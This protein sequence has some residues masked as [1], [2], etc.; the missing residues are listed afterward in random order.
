MKILQKFAAVLVFCSAVLFAS[1]ADARV[2]QI[3]DMGAY[4]LYNDSNAV[5]AG[6]GNPYRLNNLKH[7]G[8]MSPDSYYDLYVAGI[9]G[10]GEGAVI[11]FFC[12]EKGYVSKIVIM[13]N[14][15]N[16]NVAG[17]VGSALGALMIAMG[18]SR[19]E[20]AMLTSSS[21][22]IKNT[23]H[24]EAWVSAL[25]CRVIH[26]TSCAPDARGN[27]ILMVRLTAEDS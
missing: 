8:K 12:N 6:I 15:N 5:L 19:D 10:G 25:N 20:F 17:Y 2:V 3:C 24:N 13:A 1:S 7:V 26:E 4:A 14:G 11:S 23:R 21:P 22:I 9:G 16:S 18:V 27:L